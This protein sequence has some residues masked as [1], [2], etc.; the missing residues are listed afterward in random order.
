V[1]ILPRHPRSVARPSSTEQQAEAGDPVPI[2]SQASHQ[3]IDIGAPGWCWSRLG[4]G[5][6]GI[7]SYETARGRLSLAVPY[8]VIG[9]RISIALASFNVT[10]W[11]AAGS[12][13]RLEVSGTTPDGLRWVVRVTGRAD[14][15][16]RSGPT[17]AAYSRQVHPSNGVGHTSAVRPDRLFLREPRVRGFHAAAR[18]V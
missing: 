2:P 7:L 8:V 17:G 4:L 6:E 12:D 3:V 1:A 5:G 10:G 18:P 13:T 11:R 16:D 15:G 9:R 14:P